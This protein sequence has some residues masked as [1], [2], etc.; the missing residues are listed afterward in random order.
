MGSSSIR[1]EIGTGKPTIQ[2]GKARRQVGEGRA[3][4]LLDR[5]SGRGLPSGDR[6]G[7]VRSPIARPNRQGEVH[8]TAV[9]IDHGMID[10]TLWHL[11]E[12]R[13]G[14]RD[15]LRLRHCHRPG[16][17]VP[18]FESIGEDPE[19]HVVD[20][21]FQDRPTVPGSVPGVL[22]QEDLDAQYNKAKEKKDTLG[23]MK[24]KMLKVFSKPAA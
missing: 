23:M 17:S 11:P 9:A 20:R 6:V 18:R 14:R 12:P 4:H 5:V 8:S 10:T 2:N 16:G 19:K 24:A 21:I 7:P 15:P 13:R 3:T 1:C 22:K